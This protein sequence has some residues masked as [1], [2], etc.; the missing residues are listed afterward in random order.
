MNSCEVNQ[1]QSMSSIASID[2]KPQ[3]IEDYT[4]ARNCQDKEFIRESDQVLLDLCLD[5]QQT[6][7]F[8]KTFN[9]IFL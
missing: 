5:H 6:I 8:R 2:L 1:A 4:F 9:R 3:Q 7:Q